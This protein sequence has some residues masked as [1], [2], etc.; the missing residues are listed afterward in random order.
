MDVYRLQ[1]NG[2]APIYGG[3]LPNGSTTSNL[4][5]RTNINEVYT[6]SNTDY[7]IQPEPYNSYDVDPAA[8]VAAV[9]AYA[10]DGFVYPHM[11][12]DEERRLQN[13]YVLGTP[14]E[15]GNYNN[16]WDNLGENQK[17]NLLDLAY[18]SE[19]TK[20]YNR[21]ITNVNDQIKNGQL[22]PLNSYE[23]INLDKLY[24]HGS[25]FVDNVQ[26]RLD[27]FIRNAEA[28][29]RLKQYYI[30]NPHYIDPCPDENGLRGQADNIVGQSTI[31]T[32]EMNKNLQKK[33]GL[34]SVEQAMGTNI[35]DNGRIAN[36]GVIDAVMN[37]TTNRATNRRLILQNTNQNKFR[38]VVQRDPIVEQVYQSNID[39][40]KMPNKQLISDPNKIRLS[41]ITNAINK[42]DGIKPK[43][44]NRLIN[45]YSYDN[46]KSRITN[47]LGLVTYL[48]DFMR[49][50][51]AKQR[52][53]EFAA[54]LTKLVDEGT[55]PINSLNIL[56]QEAPSQAHK[57]DKMASVLIAEA[58]KQNLPQADREAIL[59]F[60]KTI[61][62]DKKGSELFSMKK[63]EQPINMAVNSFSNIKP[64]Q[65]NP[66]NISDT[67]Y[68]G[69]KGFAGSINPSFSV[70]KDL[71]T[72]YSSPKFNNPVLRNSYGQPSVAHH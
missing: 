20:I 33:W 56:A 46:S 28:A 15:V 41:E 44:I 5:F 49:A 61:D 69:N 48:C 12:G 16:F 42:I 47:E 37:N 58:N 11:F 21:V 59:A 45:F 72:M 57:L 25:D 36:K 65:I 55:I 27:T 23:P 43:L 60:I 50:V 39:A 40:K 54:I 3:T 22:K 66:I 34:E 38:N 19:Q 1:T 68:T 6:D 13:K 29:T 14:E 52:P 63:G 62:K 10:E 64:K 30:N 53:K 26:P 2:I 7:Y 9:S 32:I 70:A 71:N 51:N 4:S 17:K 31:R 18:N 67:S 24:S 8:T 35:G